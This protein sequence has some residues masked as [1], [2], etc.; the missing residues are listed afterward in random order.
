MDSSLN[1]QHTIGMVARRTRIH[2][3]TLRVWERRYELIV[4]GRSETGRRLYSEQDI[5]KISLVK[6]LTELG[7]PVSGLA[8]L[9][10][11][12]LKHQLSHTLNNGK[13]GL[14]N[15][16]AKF[17][18]VFASEAS[19][20]RWAHELLV[21]EDINIDNGNAAKELADAAVLVM[22]MPTV[23]L[24]TY[25]NVKLSLR[26]KHCSHAIVIC[27]FG[28]KAAIQTLERNAIVCLK[29]AVT[30]ADIHRVC[31]SFRLESDLS[32]VSQ[33]P[34]SSVKPRRFSADQLSRVA[35]MSSSIACE[36]PNHL[37]EMIV[38]LAAFEQYSSECASRDDKDAQMHLQLNQSTGHARSILEE[39]L[40]RLMESEGISI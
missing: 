17:R 15:R 3:E 33:K 27:N 39:S 10:I 21:Y 6:Q 26:D 23:D 9:S 32:G 18:L 29:G 28:T 13:A 35:S 11:E 5:L 34:E 14:R 36:C 22:Y 24:E 2:P 8:K 25:A 4:P 38:S 40:V 1:Y 20:R 16:Q 37:A 31:L 19:R 7:H 12:A 30:A